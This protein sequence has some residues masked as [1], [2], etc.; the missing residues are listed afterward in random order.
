MLNYAQQARQPSCPEQDKERKQRMHCYEL[1]SKPGS[2]AARNRT[3]DGGGSRDGGVSGET[4]GAGKA[5]G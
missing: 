2:R 5:T 3:V 4:A 1:E